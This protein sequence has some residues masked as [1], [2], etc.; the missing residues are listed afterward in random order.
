MVY[1]RCLS[2][3]TDCHSASR[4]TLMGPWETNPPVAAGI[5]AKVGRTSNDNFLAWISW[6]LTWILN[7]SNQHVYFS[8][9]VRGTGCKERDNFEAAFQWGY[10]C[11]ATWYFETVKKPHLYTEVRS[12][13]LWDF[14]FFNVVF[15]AA[16]WQPNPTE[17]CCSQVHR[18][19]RSWGWEEPEILC[20][21]KR[22][23]LWCQ[24]HPSSAL[25]L[26]SKLPNVWASVFLLV[27]WD[28]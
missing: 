18:Q 4:P 25:S 3:S 28:T 2:L 20:R 12:S 17:K 9:L 8:K 26:L 13:K 24:L 1:R 11:L 27:H 23:R 5:R 19:S 10:V 7:C 6:S 16:Y 15:G 21:E 14:Y 22:C